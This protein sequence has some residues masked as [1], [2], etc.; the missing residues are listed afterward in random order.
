MIKNFFKCS[1]AVIGSCAVLRGS[2]DPG[3]PEAVASHQNRKGVRT[4]AHERFLGFSG[5]SH[6]VYS[7][8]RT[9]PDGITIM[10]KT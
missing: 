10:A 9:S 4:T 8:A 3:N 1:G 5:L 6:R 7:V 2:A